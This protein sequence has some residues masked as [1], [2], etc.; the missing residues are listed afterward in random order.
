MPLIGWYLVG[1]SLLACALTVWDKHC[2]RRGRWR[3]PE[4]TLF[5]VALLGGALAM[6]VT[7]RVVRHKTRHR[8]FMWGLPLVVLAQL[9]A[10]AWFASHNSHF[11]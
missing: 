6:L 10:A 4:K 5:S 1:V 9:A 8:R 11:S 7:M 3:T 2:A